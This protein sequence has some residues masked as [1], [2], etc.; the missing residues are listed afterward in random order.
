VKLVPE[1]RQPKK[2]GTLGTVLP[3][4]PRCPGRDVSLTSIAKGDL[5]RQRVSGTT[6]RSGPS[7]GS[8]THQGMPLPLL[9]AQRARA[10]WHIATRGGGKLSMPCPAHLDEG[11][12]YAPVCGDPVCWRQTKTI[13]HKPGTIHPPTV[14]VRAGYFS[15]QD[16]GT[17]QSKEQTVCLTPPPSRPAQ[18]LCPA[19]TLDQDARPNRLRNA[20]LSDKNRPKTDDRRLVH[21]RARSDGRA[22]VIAPFS[23]I[24]EFLGS[25]RTR[26]FWRS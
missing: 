2:P 9:V 24:W 25:S 15:A 4:L 6:A 26:G 20:P 16:M 1:R 22:C 10:L 21:I 3:D 5:F 17:W 13:G 8:H 19:A 23:Y 7:R 18:H 12:C 11:S 14:R